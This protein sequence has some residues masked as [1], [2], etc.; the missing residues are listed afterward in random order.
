M[1]M[2]KWEVQRNVHSIKGSK[3]FL[4]YPIQK[5]HTIPQSIV[6]HFQHLQ[7]R[8]LISTEWEVPLDRVKLPK[9]NWSMCKSVRSDMCPQF[10]FITSV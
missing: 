9:E 2:Y 4:G 10:F 5:L 6:N 8:L 3:F 7:S 1:N